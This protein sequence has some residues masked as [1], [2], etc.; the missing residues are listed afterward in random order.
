MIDPVSPALNQVSLSPGTSAPAAK[1]LA[2]AG[3]NF[4]SALGDAA[5]KVR[6]NLAN[7]EK[8]SIDG[9]KGEAAVADVVS[10]VME[11]ERSLRLAIGIRDKIV[12]AWMEVS[13]M[14]I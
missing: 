8:T 4:A 13:R 9:M 3:D 12:S 10:A 14:Q 2:D 11:A 5:M 7:A 6:D 1:P